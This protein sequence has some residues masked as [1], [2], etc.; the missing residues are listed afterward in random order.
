[1]TWNGNMEI[2]ESVSRTVKCDWIQENKESGANLYQAV[3]LLYQFFICQLSI[4]FPFCFLFLSLSHCALSPFNSLKH[5]LSPLAALLLHVI[6]CILSLHPA[7]LVPP[8]H[9]SESPPPPIRL[10]LLLIFFF[11]TSSSTHLL[12]LY[13]AGSDLYW[14]NTNLAANP[15]QAQDQDPKPWHEALT[16]TWSH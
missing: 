2:L 12:S 6:T 14:C 13:L 9:Q 7:A 3:S 4:I 8:P 10:F 11:V 16:R 15:I 5:S 1:M